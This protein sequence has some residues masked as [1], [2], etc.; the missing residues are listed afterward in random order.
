MNFQDEND[1]K[2]I[3]PMRYTETALEEK[4]YLAELNKK[5]FW[6]K[7]FGYLKLSGPGFMGAAFTLGA[8]SF[9]SSVSLGAAYGYSMLWIPL[10]SFA[11]GLFMLALATRFVTAS[12]MP[13]IQ[14][15]NKYHGKFIGSFATGLAACSIA[16]VVFS[17]GQYALGAD[18]VTSIFALAGFNVPKE[19]SW[20]AIFA[21]SVPLALLYGRGNNPKLVKF[22]EDAMKF[23]IFIMLVVFGAILFTT[24]INF[25]EM[26]KG[27]LIPT[28]PTGIDGIVMFIASL[29]ATIGVMDWVLFNNSMYAR[30]YS[31]EHE[32]LGRF[33]SVMGGLL[34]TV[35]VL[36]FVSVAF[37]EVFAGKPGIPTTSGE[38]ASALVSIIPSIWIQIGFYVG[39]MALIISTMVGLSILAAT[40]FCQSLNLEADSK[41]WYWTA[42]LLS[43]HI[44]FLGAFFGKPVAVV[45]TVAAM[46]SIFNW[47]SGMSWY[48]LGNDVR[49]LGK[50]VI[51]SR[52]FNI[53]I[54]ITITILNVVF[55]TF[56][57]SKIG[58]WPA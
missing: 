4:E 22:V 29:T 8:G 48:L 6:P 51:Q 28:L 55:I 41:K 33:D 9:A 40:S 36:T 1:V 11:F 39:I 37:A 17:F 13:I 52:I 14:A 38:L 18:A 5:P 19:I 54:L 43:P 50:K 46:Q 53:G 32:T 27:L 49:Y 56:I 44:G 12:E 23:L 31:E 15:Q 34:P 16:S 3:N 57:L 20:I 35:L 26:I 30:G 2:I 25:P 21:T 47:L 10:Y 45:I 7:F 24:G 58:V 42:L